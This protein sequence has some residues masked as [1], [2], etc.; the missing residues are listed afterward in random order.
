MK[1]KFF[2]KK[3]LGLVLLTAFSIFRVQ[4]VNAES[5]QNKFKKSR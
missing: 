4:A 5:Y 3:V 1:I 2:L